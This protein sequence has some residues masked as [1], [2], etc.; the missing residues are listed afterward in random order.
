VGRD[1]HRAMPTNWRTRSRS[2]SFEVGVLHYVGPQMRDR[3]VLSESGM[4]HESAWEGAVQ[5]IPLNDP[6]FSNP[7]APFA[8]LFQLIS[9]TNS[10]LEKHVMRCAEWTG[11]AMGD[12]NAA[13]L[14]VKAATALEVVFSSN[15]KGVITPS[16]MAQIA[17]RRAF[18][19]AVRQH[20]LLKSNVK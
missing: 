4:S 9:R 14:F 15:E 7:P 18:L 12:P 13:S 1:P 16:I 20:L 8:R 11:Q 2:R 17:E 3:I 10:D 5:R 6:F 19:L